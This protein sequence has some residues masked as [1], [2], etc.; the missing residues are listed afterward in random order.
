MSVSEMRIGR[1]E[2]ATQRERQYVIKS[3]TSESA[4]R[5]ALLAFVPA[6][7]GG[8]ALSRADS[9]VEETDE[10][11]YV[12][13]A[14]W[15]SPDGQT[16]QQDRP[17]EPDSFNLSFDISGVTQ[18]VTQAREHIADWA[19]PG[20]TP[21][22]F[23]GAIGVKPDGVEGCD[24]QYPYITHTVTYAF[25]EAAFTQ[26]F[27]QD[28]LTKAVGKT[29]NAAVDG[30]GEQELLCTRISGQKRRYSTE[31][32]GTPVY[33]WDITFGFAVSYTAIDEVIAGGE[34]VITF[35][36]MGWH[37]MWVHYVDMPQEDGDKKW[38]AKVPVSVHTE[39]VYD[40]WNYTTLG[41]FG[42][43]E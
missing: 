3:E 43:I 37:Y 17:L 11:V 32:D 30:Y 25:P 1:R 8:W 15:K 35:T 33:V 2:T 12:A 23:K 20:K 36:K 26:D 40:T 27:W 31:E 34:G 18:K 29:N 39:R 7:N 10:N 22:N 4:A 16:Q 24:V 21:R 42:E 28:V 6:T 41:I 5:A 19:A 13:T 38:T 9:D 14:V